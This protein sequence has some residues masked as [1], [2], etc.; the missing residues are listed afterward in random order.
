[1]FALHKH[2]FLG[3]YSKSVEFEGFGIWI[4]QYLPYGKLVDYIPISYPIRNNSSRVNTS[5]VSDV[6]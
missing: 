6:G 3:F 2:I 4:L 1:M 5:L